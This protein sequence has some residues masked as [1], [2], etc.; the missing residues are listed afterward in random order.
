MKTG[1][2]QAPVSVHRFANSAIDH[3]NTAKGSSQRNGAYMLERHETVPFQ[4]A[5]RDIGNVV[6]V[7]DGDT[8]HDLTGVENLDDF[9]LRGVDHIDALDVPEA[10]LV[11][12][13]KGIAAVGSEHD[14][15]L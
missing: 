15:F 10:I 12:D 11:I 9:I 4:V 1:A 3:G 8:L 6:V 5:G 7:V 13:H 14:V 2:V